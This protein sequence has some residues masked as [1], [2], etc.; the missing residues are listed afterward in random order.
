MNFLTDAFYWITTGLLVPVMV[1]LLIGFLYS[2]AMVASFYG[3]YADRRKFKREIASVLE[4][5]DTKGVESC[6]WEKTIQHHPAFLKALQSAQ[7]QQWTETRSNKALSDFEMAAAK[8]LEKPRTLMRVG[9][10]LTLIPMGPALVGL[11]S[12]DIA[13]MA[14]NMQIAFST[15]VIG[16]FLGGIGFV[17]HSVRKRWYSEDLYNLQYIMELAE[18]HENEKKPVST[19]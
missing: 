10:M 7:G 12:G 11:A 5:V 3:F 18:E 17:T 9:P 15:T 19:F 2:L 8:Q 1:L 4:E 13:S 6:D 16:I 14:T